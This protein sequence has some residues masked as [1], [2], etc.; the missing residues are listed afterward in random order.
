MESTFV[1]VQ[2]SCT[3]EPEENLRKAGV[4]AEKAREKYHADFLLYP[5]VMMIEYGPGV[6]VEERN[7]GGQSLEGPFARG[8]QEIARKNHVWIAFGMREKVSEPGDGAAQQEGEAQSAERMP[9]RRNYNS[10][11]LL[12]AEG[13]IVQVYHKTHMYDAFGYRESEEYKPGYRFFEPVDTP[14]GKVGLY[15]CYELRF[16][17]I[18]RAQRA[19]GAEIVL[20]PTAWVKGDQKSQHF[21]TLVTA[22]AIENT[23]FVLAADQYSRIRMGESVAVDP[24]GVPIAGCGEGEQLVP[25]FIDT[26]RIREVRRKLPSYED[27]RPEMYH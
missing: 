3:A 8:M 19:G 14:F 15:V 11:V 18:A 9:D 17:E 7:A 16:P 2:M 5:E 4:L 6:S 10:S 22:R 24:M 13:K 21:R 23:C 20:V 26:E 12:N 27:R 1:M 25:V